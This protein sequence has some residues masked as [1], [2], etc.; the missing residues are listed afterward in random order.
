MILEGFLFFFFKSVLF[1]YLFVINSAKM[2]NNQKITRFYTIGRELMENLQISKTFLDNT[3]KPWIETALKSPTL[4]NCK[5]AYVSNLV[6]ENSCAKSVQLTTEFESLLL[7]M[8]INDVEPEMVKLNAEISKL[9]GELRSESN[10]M[11]EASGR[12]IDPE[13]LKEQF[14]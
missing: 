1:L 2:S 11:V 6:F 13:I 4:D 7:T 14:K 3:Y 8:N 9:S 12:L 5:N 10:K